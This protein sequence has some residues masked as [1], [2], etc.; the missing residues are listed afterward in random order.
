MI[1]V[2]DR[3]QEQKETHRW[4]VVATDRFMSGWGPCRDGI[5]KCGWACEPGASVDALYNWVSSRSEMKYVNIVDFKT[6]RPKN[7]AHFHL[8]VCGKD[9]IS[10]PKEL[11]HESRETL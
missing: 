8:Y 7:A 11:K 2:D 10:Q 4:G 5:S 3:T 6:Y 1:K 9:H